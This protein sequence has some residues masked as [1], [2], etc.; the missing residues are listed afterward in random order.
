MARYIA[1]DWGKVR[2]GI[3]ISDSN[4]IIAS[5][6]STVNSDKLI[7]SIDKLYNE[8]PCAGFVVGVPGLIF[9]LNTDSSEG[10]EKFIKDLQTKFPSTPI[11]TVDEAQTSSE[12][13][14]AL[15]SGGVKQ[16]KRIEK[17][18]LDKVAAA[19]ILQRFLQ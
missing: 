13:F 6:H 15:I 4:G 14:D 10:I 9:G 16:S 12:A 7:T 1:F 18:T 8:E 19:L 11:H 17:G 3:A 2:T 5:P